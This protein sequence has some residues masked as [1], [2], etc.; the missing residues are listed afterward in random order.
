MFHLRPPSVSR[1]VLW[2]SLCTFLSIKGVPRCF[3][4][5][6]FSSIETG[7]PCKQAVGCGLRTSTYFTAVLL[8]PYG[9]ACI[10][11]EQK[12]QRRDQIVP[13]CKTQQILSGTNST[14][15]Q[16]ASAM[17]TEGPTLRGLGRAK[18]VS[19]NA[20]NEWMWATG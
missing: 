19:L 5:I 14:A 15:L 17:S 13:T 9:C 10:H 2:A 12:Q 11:K 20:V 3:R 16:V 1:I 18:N 4:T 7:Q 6:M 8:H